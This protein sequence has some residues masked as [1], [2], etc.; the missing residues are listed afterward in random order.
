MPT[1]NWCWNKRTHTHTHSKRASDGAR[2]R[3]MKWTNKPINFRS[4]NSVRNYCKMQQQF[5]IVSKYVVKWIILIGWI[6]IV[7]IVFG[8]GEMKFICLKNATNNGKCSLSLLHFRCILI[9][10]IYYV[11][12]INYNKL[13][14]MCPV[15]RLLYHRSNLLTDNE[16][17]MLRINEIRYKIQNSF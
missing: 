3:T 2:T 11:K 9:K 7:Y 1:R 17:A 12:N 10:G 8:V 15:Q 16:F 4:A 13:L 5:S 14:A 6:V